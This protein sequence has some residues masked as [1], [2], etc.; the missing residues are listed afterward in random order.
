MTGP[1][2]R[3]D[4]TVTML[5]T[6]ARFIDR[7]VTR[8]L[9]GI[10][11]EESLIRPEP[12]GNCINWVVGHLVDGYQ[13][14]LRAL[15]VDPV[16]EPESLA[17]YRRGELPLE[18][19]AQ[20]VELA[21]LRR[22]WDES[23]LRLGARLPELDDAALTSAPAGVRAHEGETLGSLLAGALFHQAYHAGQLGLLR[24]IVGKEGAIR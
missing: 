20:A 3:I 19:G 24:R 16:M 9:E 5:R 1:D 15:D 4:S 14:V 23:V 13:R 18:D 6:Q 22:A 17:R 8:N 7:A 12:S 11:H 2:S 21:R 10:T